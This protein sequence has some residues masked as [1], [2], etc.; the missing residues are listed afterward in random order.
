[1]I[2]GMGLPTTANYI[3][4]STLMAPVIVQ[5]SAAHGLEIPLVA[6]HLFVFYFGI[7]ADDTPPVGLA[8]YAASGISGAD[9]I[10]TGVQSFYYDIRTAILPFMFIF[11]TELLMIGVESV[12]H[13]LL[14]AATGLG[15]IL[16]FVAATQGW[17]VARN[18]WW[19]SLLLLLV[20]FSLFRPDHW[21]DQF[22]PPY[23]LHPPPQL[24][25]VIQ[26]MEPQEPLR[27][28]VETENEE[29]KLLIRTLL[30]RVPDGDPERRLEQLGFITE[31]E[32]EELR[33]LDIGFL[34]PAENAGLEAGFATRILGFE[35]QQQQPAKE[36][37]LLPPL[38]LCLLIGTLQSRRKTR[39]ADSQ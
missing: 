2:L 8:A 31:A 18:R 13:F 20:V 26:Q 24:P 27:L 36:W 9:P 29:G 25:S 12:G 34:S 1:M 21:R 17:F 32:D 39:I 37:F 5:F 6:V 23:Q 4:V 19:E 33:I 30:L 22:F 35:E 10:R 14:V 7:L 11:N 16:L 28:K 3:V 15:A 38:L